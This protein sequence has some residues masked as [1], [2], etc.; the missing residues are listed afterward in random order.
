MQHI[1]IQ[2]LCAPVDE[3]EMKREGNSFDKA[4]NFCCC[5]VLE[6]V[7]YCLDGEALCFQTKHSL[8]N[9]I[10]NGKNGF[11]IQQKKCH[12]MSGKGPECGI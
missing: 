4:G 3:N 8:F 9:L 12:C 10:Q 6:I 2:H 7:L 1:T 5:W 11:K